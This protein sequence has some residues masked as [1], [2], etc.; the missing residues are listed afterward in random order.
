MLITQLSKQQQEM[1]KFS[2]EQQVSSVTIVLLLQA[3]L[4]FLIVL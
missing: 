1:L 4:Y 2:Q 3:S